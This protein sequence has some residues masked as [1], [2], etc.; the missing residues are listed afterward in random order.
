MDHKIRNDNIVRLDDSFDSE[1]PLGTGEDC[2]FCKHAT[3]HRVC[4]A[5]ARIPDDIWYGKVEHTKP[6]PG[7]NGIL[8]EEREKKVE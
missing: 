7:D 1:V 5:F 3:N 4:K 2:Y 8:F 6:Y